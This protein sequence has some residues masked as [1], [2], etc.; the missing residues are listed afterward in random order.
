M[1]FGK[2]KKS[3]DGQDGTDGGPAARPGPDPVP[4]DGDEV[5]GPFD[6]EDFEDHDTAAVG[7]LDLGS[8]LVPMPE[9]GQVQVEVNEAGAP[10]AVWV[11]TPNG[12]FTIAAYAAPKSA[13]LWR[14][15]AAELAEALRKDTAEREHRERS[16]G[17]RGRRGRRGRGAFHRRRRI[18]LDDPLCCQRGA[19]DHWRAGR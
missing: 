8:V 12:R 11:V 2:Q 9:A 1:A 19:G 4:Q 13:G 18:P 15:V 6:I 7:R 14:E 3:K 5:E 17:P 16:V 10:S